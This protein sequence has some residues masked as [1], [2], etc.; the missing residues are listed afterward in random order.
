MF[1]IWRVDPPW[2]AVSRK[3]PGTRMG[4]G[5]AAINHYV[6][7]VKAGRVIVEVGGRCSFEEVRQVLEKVSWNEENYR[8]QLVCMN[9]CR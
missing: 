4:G 6:C 2:Y 1:A 8:Y 5:K 9:N 7:P 3:S